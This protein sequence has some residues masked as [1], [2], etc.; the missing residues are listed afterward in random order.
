MRYST[1][2]RVESTKDKNGKYTGWDYTN[3][4]LKLPPSNSNNRYLI[5]TLETKQK[6]IDE[7]F[8]KANSLINDYFVKGSV[9]YPEFL[10]SLLNSREAVQ[11]EKA[12]TSFFEYFNQFLERKRQ[13]FN[14]RGKIVSLKDYNSTLLLLKDFEQFKKIDLRVEH[15]TN[16]WL[17]DLVNYM[18]S[19]HPK[20]YG[21]HKVNSKGEMASSTIRKRL[22]IISEFFGYLKE[23]KVVTI[24]QD[25][26]IRKFKKGVKKQPT[27]KETLDISEIHKLYKFKFKQKSHEQIR[28]LFVFLCLTGIRYQDLIDFDKKFIRNSKTG[29]GLIYVKAASK[30]SLDYNIPLCK[31]VIEILEKYNYELPKITGQYGNRAIKEALEVTKLFNDYTQL[32]DKETKEYKK[33]FEVITLHKGRDSFITNLVDTTPLNELMKYTGHKKLSTLQ[34]YIDK[35]RSVK[36]D[37][38]KIF[39]LK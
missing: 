4:R 20:F 18:A 13:H 8:N 35:K 12:N 10:E 28:D 37:Y 36:M 30:T 22:D 29:D 9:M 27:Q 39:D 26:L 33:R 3:N 14:A 21:Q 5:A 25:E 34:G 1:G 16:L 24:E 15:F 6:K 23:L 7:L 31:I 38:I 32:K 11:F 17:E 2:V 19:K